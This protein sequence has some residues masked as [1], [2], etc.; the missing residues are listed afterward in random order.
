[1]EVTDEKIV[2]IQNH[3]PDLYMNTERSKIIGELSFDAHYDGKRL[4]LNPSKQREAEVFHGYYEI[5]V[6]L[7]RLNVYGLPFVFETGGKIIRFSQENNIPPSDLHLN[8][9]GSCCLGIFT[10]RESANMILST[11]VIEI[12]FSFFAWQAYASTYKRKAPWGE[13]SHAVWGFKEK[14]DDIHVNMRSAGRNDPC[15]CGSG[16]KFKNCC[17][18]QFQRINRSV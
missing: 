17:L 5:E 14:I 18:D 8:G 7:N 3:F 10:P 6:R 12:V 16:C 11:F 1:M 4:H 2:D 13:Y 15:P 9:D